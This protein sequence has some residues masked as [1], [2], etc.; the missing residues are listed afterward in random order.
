[1]C[2]GIAGSQSWGHGTKGPNE[3]ARGG[4]CRNLL[5]ITLSPP[6]LSAVVI[7]QECRIQSMM[8]GKG[9]GGGIKLSVFRA[10]SYHL[11]AL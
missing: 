9:A 10:Q 1:M 7:R 2:C 8:C 3:P 4:V 11:L 6:L 5:V